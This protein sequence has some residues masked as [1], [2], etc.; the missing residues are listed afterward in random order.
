MAHCKHTYRSKNAIEIDE[1]HTGKYG[2]PGQP[3]QKKQKAT[4]EQI[5]RINQ[6][7][8][9][10]LARRKMRNHFD[11]GDYFSCMT[12]RRAERPPNMDIAKK[13]FEKFIDRVRVEYRKRGYELKW[14]RNIEVGTKNG[15]HIHLIINRIPDTDIILAKAWP[16]GKVVSQLLYEKG[17]FAQLAAYIT[18]TPKTD[19]KLKEASYSTSRNLPVPPPEKKIVYGWKLTDK[20]RVPKGY[21]LDKQS[22]REGVNPVTGYGYRSYTLLKLQPVRRRAG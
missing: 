17:E 5:E 20:I 2:A 3:R 8:R 6:Y 14:I 19:N 10:K 15:W 12:Y 22:L 4:P 9:E 13:Q 18:K 21:Y 1:F 11:V 16:F 7:N